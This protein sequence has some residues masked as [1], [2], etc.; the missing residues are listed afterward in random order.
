MKFTFVSVL[1]FVTILDIQSFIW[2]KP[3]HIFDKVYN[4]CL[5]LKNPKMSIFLGL[6]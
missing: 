1:L 5:R 4:A 6:S 3:Q 2:Y